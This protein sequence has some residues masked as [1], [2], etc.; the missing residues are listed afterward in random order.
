LISTIAT[1]E[2]AVLP[3]GRL[4]IGEGA[5]INYGCSIA[6]QKQIYIGSNCSIGPHVILMDNDFHHLEPE[7]RL[8]R[9]ESAPIILEENVWLAAR[10]I[11]LS[12]VRIGAHSVIG[13]GSVVTKDIPPR[14]LAAGIPAK[15]IK[16]L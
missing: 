11:V 12:G 2:I 13:A 3:L 10:V 14:V 4:E 9:P 7:L 1:T 15:V 16:Q 6:A 5:F 8:Q